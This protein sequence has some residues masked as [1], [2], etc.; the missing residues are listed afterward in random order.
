MPTANFQ[1]HSLTLQS[2][3]SASGEAS[4]WARALADRA[5]LGEARTYA[6]DL[7]I[8]ELVTNVV[9]HGYRD[10]PGVIRLELDLAPTAAVLTVLDTAP[11]FDPLS[12]PA[13]AKPASLDEA[14][15]G[16][17]GVHM[18]RS[19]AM[20]CRYER[21]DGWNVFTASFGTP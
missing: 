3:A 11:A 7:C 1:R 13:P 4:A 18:V 12:V 20:G 21:R 6:L 14:P 15:I 8:V 9:G 17:Y 16:G 5:G 2:G 19:T 10:G